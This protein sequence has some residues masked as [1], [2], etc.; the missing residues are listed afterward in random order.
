MRHRE[1]RPATNGDT[2]TNDRDW[3]C[4]GGRLIVR[5]IPV[6]LPAIEPCA[7]IDRPNAST[8]RFEDRQFSSTAIATAK[9]FRIDTIFSFTRFANDRT[10]FTTSRLRSVKFFPIYSWMLDNRT[11]LRS[12]ERNISTYIRSRPITDIHVSLNVEI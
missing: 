7:T 1:S 3:R 6:A 5:L 2:I 8:N 10:D 12:V 9:R 4:R 11:V